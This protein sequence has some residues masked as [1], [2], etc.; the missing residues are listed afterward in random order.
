MALI[1]RFSDFF[2]GKKC[3]RKVVK[4]NGFGKEIFC[5]ELFHLLSTGL[6]RV[7]L[8]FLFFR[9]FNATV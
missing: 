2:L 7:N 6:Y 3:L 4:D 9:I 1:F 5:Q 8:N